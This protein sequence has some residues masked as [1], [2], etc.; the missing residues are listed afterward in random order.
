MWQFKRHGERVD[1]MYNPRLG[2]GDA[3]SAISNEMCGRQPDC[4][5]PMR[6]TTEVSDE[7]RPEIG[8]VTWRD[9]TVADAQAVRDFYQQVIGWKAERQS[10]GDYDDFNMLTPDTGQCVAG[11]CHDRGSNANLPPQWLIYITVEDADKSAAKCLE[12]GGKIVDGPRG[13]G[14][15]RFAVIQDPAGAVAAVISG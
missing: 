10:M 13:M 7:T 6:R 11:I 14:Q 2:S 8:A 1:R 9:L 4:G 3:L 12:M 15:Y 5:P